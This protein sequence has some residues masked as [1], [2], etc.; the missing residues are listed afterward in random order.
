MAK[1][2][3]AYE[4]VLKIICA[5]KGWKVK[6]SVDA[7]NLLATILNNTGLEQFYKNPLQ[8]VFIIRNE[9]SIAHG[10]GTQP[11]EVSEY[12]ANFAINS[13]ASAIQFLVAAAMP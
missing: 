6:G 1:C 11:R 9:K 13:S 12:V 3:S 2:A 8:I 5:R 10:A 7:A 4:S